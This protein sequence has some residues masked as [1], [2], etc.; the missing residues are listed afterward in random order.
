MGSAR[1]MQR[2]DPQAHPPFNVVSIEK[3][4]ANEHI[5]PDAIVV[6]SATRDARQ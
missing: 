5:R 1:H 2:I 3:P 4:S 6:T